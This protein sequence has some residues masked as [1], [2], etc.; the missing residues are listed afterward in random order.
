M[1]ISCECKGDLRE[2]K[3]LSIGCQVNEINWGLK[4]NEN[5]YATPNTQNVLN[6]YI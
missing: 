5:K 1:N 6:E 4:E 2:K 3:E